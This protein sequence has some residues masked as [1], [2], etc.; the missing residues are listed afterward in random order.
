MVGLRDYTL[1]SEIVMILQD[2]MS[3]GFISGQ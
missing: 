3:S 1:H 2:N